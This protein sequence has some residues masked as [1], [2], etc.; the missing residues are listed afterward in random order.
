MLRHIYDRLEVTGDLTAVFDP[1][2]A[3][4]LEKAIDHL[5][6][7][8]QGKL[9]WLMAVT[10]VKVGSYRWAVNSLLTYEQV[11]GKTNEE[12]WKMFDNYTDKHIEAVV[13][14]KVSY[15]MY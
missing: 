6:T 12:I 5:G 10:K 11:A 4:G 2:A 15:P 13:R 9:V 1:K 3:D 8:H 14:A 7:V